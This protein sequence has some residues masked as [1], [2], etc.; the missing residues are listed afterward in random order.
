MGGIHAHQ[1][2]LTTGGR[3]AASATD[4]DDQAFAAQGRQRIPDGIAADPEILGERGLGR[5]RRSRKQLADLDLLPQD[6]RQLPVDR[7]EAGLVDRHAPTLE[8]SYTHEGI[9]PYGYMAMYPRAGE[10]ADLAALD[11]G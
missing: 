6:P 7:L 1:A 5:Q 3:P 11:C 9:W 4:G 8:T 2:R 10:A